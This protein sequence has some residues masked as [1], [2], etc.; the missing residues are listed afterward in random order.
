M[1]EVQK[2]ILTCLLGPEDPTAFSRFQKNAYGRER[3]ARNP[4]K[5]RSAAR[6]RTQKYRQSLTGEEKEAALSVAREGMRK[7]RL[8]NPEAV[9]ESN[10]R[11]TEK[12]PTAAR[13]S[14][15]KQRERRG[16]EIKEVRRI[17]RLKNLARC[18]NVKNKNAVKRYQGEGS[19]RANKC[20]RNRLNNAVRRA[21]AQKGA[22]TMELTGCPWVWLEYHLESQFKPGMTWENHGSVWQIDHIKPCAS[23]DLTDP[24][25]QRICF[26][27]TN[28]QPLFALEN[29]QKSDKYVL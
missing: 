25:Q 3:L 19:Y 24:E 5:A 4:D 16:E 17:W 7:H 12:N 27:W 28:L 2:I 9:A 26:H 29:L 1:N 11:Y 6:V 8:E 22:R 18:R 15:R 13:D 10:R 21:K 14:M 23:F 20:L